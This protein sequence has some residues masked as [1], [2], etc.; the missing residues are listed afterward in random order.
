MPLTGH[1]ILIVESEIGFFARELQNALEAAGAQTL[2]VRS[3]LVAL[4]R[5][6]EWKFTAVVASKE[7]A[8]IKARVKL[9]VLS[10]IC[11][12]AWLKCASS[13]M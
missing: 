4:V 5:M 9:P 6:E 10:V 2:M 3:V 11:N 1:N 12:S 7:H 8:D 13:V